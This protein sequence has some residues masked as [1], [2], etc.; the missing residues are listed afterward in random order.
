[1]YWIKSNHTE[2]ISCVT[3]HSDPRDSPG[4]G[5]RLVVMA[6]EEV[7]DTGEPELLQHALVEPRQGDEAEQ[8]GEVDLGESFGQV[9][10]GG[11]IG[12]EFVVDIPNGEEN[13]NSK[14]QYL[15]NH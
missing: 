8:D 6:R 7:P 13:R 4:E 14:E 5:T 12:E 3:F 10:D 2:N 1:M 9:S 15:Y 11:L